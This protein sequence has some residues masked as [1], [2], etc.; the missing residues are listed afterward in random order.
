M[1]IM[2]IAGIK[3]Y[4]NI[5]NGFKNIFKTKLKKRTFLNVFVSPSACNSELSAT[6]EIK[7]IDPDS[8]SAFSLNGGSIFELI[9]QA[10]VIRDFNPSYQII[11]VILGKNK[12]INKLS[13]SLSELLLNYVDDIYTNNNLEELK[14]AIR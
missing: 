13:Q 3:P 1:T 12:K 11:A 6:T 5:N 10:M 14:H 8:K 9:G 2:P 7:T 4:P